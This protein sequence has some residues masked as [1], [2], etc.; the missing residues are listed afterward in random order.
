MC[1]GI[2]ENICV[3]QNFKEIEPKLIDLKITEII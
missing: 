2:E 3:I 1:Y